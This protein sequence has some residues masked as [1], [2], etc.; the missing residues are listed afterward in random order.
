MV[1]LVLSGLS[2]VGLVR[3]MQQVRR[4]CAWFLAIGGMP[5]SVVRF[6]MQV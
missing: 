2:L 1:G 4:L 5:V 6:W 3:V